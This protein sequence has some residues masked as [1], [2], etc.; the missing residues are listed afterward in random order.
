MTAAPENLRINKVVGYTIS[1]EISYSWATLHVD[2]PPEPHESLNGLDA[3]LITAKF[4]SDEI[5]DEKVILRVVCHV[6]SACGEYLL[7][8]SYLEAVEDTHRF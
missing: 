5:G 7:R 3:M 1:L 8:A 4:S 2:A 6:E